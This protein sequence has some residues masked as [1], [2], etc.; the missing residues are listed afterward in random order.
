MNDFLNVE[1]LSEEDI[2]AILGLG[3]GEDQA[4]QLEQQ[5]AVAQGIR[6]RSGP[7]GRGYGGIYTAASPLE[8]AAY[9]WQGI[10]AGKDAE[11]LNAEQDALMQQQTDARR[12][13]FEAMMLKQQ[14]QQQAPQDYGPEA[15]GSPGVY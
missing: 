11:K 7:E 9:A 14:P 13:F 6:G 3:T 10:Q 2:D 8:H 5:L 15:F 12:R 1:D 4:A